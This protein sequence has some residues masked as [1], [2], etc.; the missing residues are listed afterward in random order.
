[1]RNTIILSLALLLFSQFA[2]SQN[3]VTVYED[4][5]YTGRS[6]FLEAGN[7]RSYQM[8]ISNDR[9]SAVRVPYG[10]KIT[11]Y[12]ND[13]FTGRSKTFSA[14]EACFTSEWNE[15]ASSIVV[16][17]IYGPGSGYSP[18]DY[19]IF[20][21]DAYNRGYS[22]SLRPGT[23]TGAQLGNLKYTISSFTI[24]GN[25]RVKLYPNSEDLSGYSETFNESRSY[26][27]SNI[28]DK[29]GSLVIEYKTTPAII[30]PPGGNGYATGNFATFYSACNYEG[31]ALR[32]MPGYYS[33]EKLGVLKYSI[34][35]IQVPATLQVKAFLNDNLYGQ[36]TTIIENNSCLDYDLK[37]KIGSLVIEE[38]SSGYYNGG[39]YNPIAQGNVIIYTDGSYRGQSA[40]LLPGTYAT[41]SQAGSFPDK[42]LS[43]LQV[44]AGYTV[45]LYEQ[46]NFRGKSYTITA[47]KAGF[48]FSNWNDRTSS[49]KVFRN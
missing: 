11:V 15:M 7:Y 5:N 10:F 43:S 13:G 36:S 3:Y 21:T 42:A 19:V 2:N 29:V 44:P 30:T 48:S 16:E 46:E 17:S 34:E 23:Y 37:S 18:N 8:K 4:C 9:L 40:T 45:I 35:S 27:M 26:L 32:L 33:G 47:S 28:N 49:I 41:M 39:G 24:S 1:M 22:Q 25:L 31:N 12:E 6:Y 20:Y 38:R 14:D